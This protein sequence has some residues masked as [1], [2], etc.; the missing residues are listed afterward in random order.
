MKQKKKNRFFTFIFSFLPGAAEMYMGFMK[1]GFSLMIFFLMP[2]ALV[3]I[4]GGLDF[5]M[6]ICA[7]MWFYGFFHA[8]NY[9]GLDD[10]SFAALEDRYIWEEF[11]DLDFSKVSVKTARKWIAIALIVIG[12]A[13]IWDYFS[14]ILYR[15]IP[16]GYWDDIYPALSNIPQVVISV[17][18][19]II[20]IRMII[21]KKKELDST[22]S[23]EVKPIAD[24]ARIEDKS[25]DSKEA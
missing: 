24:I 20:G 1:N 23:T 11:S 5:L 9:A 6:P 19:V 15:L 2:F 22:G 13:L 8:R 21:G 10:Q 25:L 7:V 17:L 3:V 14:S 16:E 18:M 4:Y 12:A